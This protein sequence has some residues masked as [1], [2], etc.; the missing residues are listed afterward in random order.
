MGIDIQDIVSLVCIEFHHI[1]WYKVIFPLSLSLFLCNCAF[2]YMYVGMNQVA[3][4]TISGPAA[5]Q[6][7]VKDTGARWVGWDNDVVPTFT[8]LSLFI[9]IFGIKIFEN[10]VQNMFSF[11]PCG[12]PLE[13]IS[14]YLSI[15]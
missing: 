15:I 1:E 13:K 2:V 8:P 11:V 6:C 3:E 4:S 7:K 12:H 14:I 9:V 5:L 10:I